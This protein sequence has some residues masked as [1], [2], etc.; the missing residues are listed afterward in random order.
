MSPILEAA[1]LRRENME[2]RGQLAAERAH[3]DELRQRMTEMND[4]IAV[5]RVTLAARHGEPVR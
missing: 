3:N 2:L 1:A 5:L 4:E